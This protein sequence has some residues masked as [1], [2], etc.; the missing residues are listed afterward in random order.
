MTVQMGPW[1]IW[2]SKNKDGGKRQENQFFEIPAAAGRSLE[3]GPSASLIR[4]SL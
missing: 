3:V 4:K 2:H 1:L